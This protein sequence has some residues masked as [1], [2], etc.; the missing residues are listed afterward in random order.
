MHENSLTLFARYALPYFDPTMRVL[1][2]GP[3]QLPST[4]EKV[5]AGKFASWDTADLSGGPTGQT[6]TMSMENEYE[7]PAPDGSFDIVISAS[8]IEHVR[9]PWRWH[10][11]LA[12]VCCAGGLVMTIA[13][14]SWPEHKDATVPFDGWRILSDGMKVLLEDSGLEP[15]LIRQE[16]LE[17]TA[18]S[19][20]PWF[21]G[22]TYR[23]LLPPRRSLE[24]K[25]VAITDRLTRR[26]RSAA[27]DCI[28]IGR[29]PS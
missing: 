22:E 23:F 15:L 5:A 19:G 10:P 17:R 3:D 28:A 26:P 9:R 18:S 7:I 16:S 27:V 14:V 21:P 8:V 13:P 2:I 12:R 24:A 20:H 4:F 25:L 11:E 1:E 29:K 6:A